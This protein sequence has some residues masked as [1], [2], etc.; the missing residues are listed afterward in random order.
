V[1]LTEAVA[2][3]QAVIASPAPAQTA[4]GGATD[5]NELVGS[6][7]KDLGVTPEQAR[8]GAG[9]LFSLAK[10]KMPA[11]DFASAV[12]GMDGLLEAA[13]AMGGAVGSLGTMAAAASATGF[14]GAKGGADVGHLSPAP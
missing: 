5:S 4:A 10:G 1:R 11:A 6:L 7:T 12:P 3:A 9:S 8:G 2:T 14:V 13:P